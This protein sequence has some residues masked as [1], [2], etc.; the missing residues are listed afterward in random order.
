MMGNI[1][2]SKVLT[3]NLIN[4][5]L[6]AQ[7]KDEAIDQLSQLLLEEGI[8][9]NKEHFIKDVYLREEEGT[10]G[11][12]HGIAIPH[13]KSEF[14]SRTA[15]AIG[16]LVNPIDWESLD[17]EKVKI[18]ILFAVRDIDSNTTHIRLLQKI[19]TLL[20]DDD[21]LEEMKNVEDEETLLK[22]L[23]RDE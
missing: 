5:N 15:I 3:K 1:T 7:N 17:D 21:L 6:D 22:L 20:A 11:I 14:V 16:K 2:I 8:L 10:T 18:V 19:A 23:S 13:G 4:I 12:G 9:S